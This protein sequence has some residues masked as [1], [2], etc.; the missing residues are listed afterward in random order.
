MRRPRD[1]A[2]VSRNSGSTDQDLPSVHGRACDEF[3]KALARTLEE[4]HAPGHGGL[5]L[6]KVPLGTES[7][8]RRSS[9]SAPLDR[10]TGRVHRTRTNCGIDTDHGRRTASILRDHLVRYRR[11]STISCGEG[12]DRLSSKAAFHGSSSPCADD[13]SRVATRR[14][15][16]LRTKHAY[17][18]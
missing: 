5:E 8:Q 7:E 1:R 3:H 10:V 2:A 15:R 4:K 13:R 9:N 14:G 12:I 17:R 18:R 6:T 11:C 16:A